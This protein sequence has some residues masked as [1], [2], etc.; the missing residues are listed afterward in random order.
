MMDMFSGNAITAAGE[1]SNPST[2]NHTDAKKTHG[3][4]DLD[5]DEVMDEDFSEEIGEV[6][7]ET[8]EEEETQ[9]ELI[10]KDHQLKMKK[11]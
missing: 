2:W 7:E 6:D 9:V 5:L 8:E 10:L 3:E 4:E 1:T 11:N